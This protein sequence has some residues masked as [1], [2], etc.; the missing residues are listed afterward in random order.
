MGKTKNIDPNVEVKFH[1]HKD[2]KPFTKSR[3]EYLREQVARI[4]LMP[5]P[6]QRT[7]AWYSMRED[8]ITASD[9][10]TALDQSPYQKQSKLLWKKV[11]KDRTFNTNAAIL[12]GVKY[13]EVAVQ[14]YE[15][16]NSVN[17]VEYGCI[18]HPNYNWLGASPDG[19]TDDGVMLEIKCPSSRAITGVIPSYYW[20]QVQGQLE[21]CELDRCDFLECKLVEYDSRDEYEKDNF[22]GDYFLNS[23]GKEKGAVIEYFKK[24]SKSYKFSYVPLGLMGNELDEWVKK[25]RQKNESENVLFSGIDFWRLERVSCIP[26]YRNQEWFYEVTP[27]FKKFWDQVLYYREAGI[28]ALNKYL[29][30]EK[31]KSRKN[32]KPR[33]K[34]AK[35]K[36]EKEFLFTSISD[37]I[38]LKNT[39]NGEEEIFKG[40]EDQNE[41]EKKDL[42]KG[43]FVIMDGKKV[44]IDDSSLFSLTGSSDKNKIVI[45]NNS[46]DVTGCLFSKKTFSIP[47]E[48]E[49]EEE[50]FSMKNNNLKGC[51]FSKKTFTIPDKQVTNRKRKNI[52]FGQIEVEKYDFDEDE[53]FSIKM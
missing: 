18:K 6:E 34:R 1:L 21:V 17:V 22:N 20:C 44:E 38:D 49:S 40:I 47:K 46:F 8:R 7:E 24:E 2:L 31:E 28:D 12:W 37:Y 53:L 39:I 9:F 42:L 52:K 16:R 32:R 26:I 48:E 45:D 27:I 5:Q 36:P 4:K 35:K 11:T 3:L 51:V 41:Q 29:E 43:N 19:I 33:K 23:L 10:A 50:E 13:E 25:D 30:E 15:Y 14:I